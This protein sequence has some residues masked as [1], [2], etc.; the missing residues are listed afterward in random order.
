M[1]AYAREHLLPPVSCVTEPPE[2][3]LMTVPKLKV[4]RQFRE[5]APSYLALFLARFLVNNV[6]FRGL[7][8][9]T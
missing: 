3:Y 1:T 4:I 5:Y 2:S 9:C 8:V 7:A 6:K